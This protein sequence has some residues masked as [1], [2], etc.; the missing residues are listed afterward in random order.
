VLH[1]AFEKAVAAYQ[2]AL[3]SNQG[4]QA[5]FAAMFGNYGR[6]YIG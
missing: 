4:L 2:A 3:E 6:I 1:A 5:N